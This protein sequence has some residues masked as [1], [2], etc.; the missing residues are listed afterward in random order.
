VAT[1]DPATGRR[2][3][4]VFVRGIPLIAAVVPLVFW[5]HFGHVGTFAIAF[6]LALIA[7]LASIAFGLWN[8]ERTE[9]ERRRTGRRPG[10]G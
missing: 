9:A 5:L 8:L 10:P 6:T 3:W 4:L 2:S 1:P 7:L